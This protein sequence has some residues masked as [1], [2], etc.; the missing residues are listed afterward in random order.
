[1]VFAG[2]NNEPMTAKTIGR[3]SA[4]ISSVFLL[5]AALFLKR[6]IHFLFLP[7]GA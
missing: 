6:A 7:R 3:F 1:M 2:I 5:R 4:R